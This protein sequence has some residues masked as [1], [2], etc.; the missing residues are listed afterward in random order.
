MFTKSFVEE[1]LKKGDVS[2]AHNSNSYIDL[3]LQVV[4]FYIE[5]KCPDVSCA[6]KS[7]PVTSATYYVARG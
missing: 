7:V 2:L 5:V 6:M 4:H 3:W 1:A